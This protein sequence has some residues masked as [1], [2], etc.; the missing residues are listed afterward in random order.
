MAIPD[1]VNELIR[2]SG[3]TLAYKVLLER[4]RYDDEEFKSASN[5]TTP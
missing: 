5:E 1:E 2:G 4:L 3:N